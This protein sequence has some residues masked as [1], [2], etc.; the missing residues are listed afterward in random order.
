MKVA[1]LTKTKVTPFWDGI[2][3]NNYWYRFKCKHWK[4]NIQQAKGLKLYKT[5]GLT[6]NSCNFS[7][8]NL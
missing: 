8:T 3:S 6:P 4:F 2:P 7:Y 1:K 5:W